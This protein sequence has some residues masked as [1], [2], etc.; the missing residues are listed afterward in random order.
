MRAL[1]PH[2]LEP[3]WRAFTKNAS[4]SSKSL[5]SVQSAGNLRGKRV[6]LR[7]GVN[8]PVKNGKVTNDFRLLSMLPTVKFLRESG[9][10]TIV[11]GHIGR[12]PELSLRPV[13]E[14]L[15]KHVPAMFVSDTVGESAKQA[16][17]KLSDGEILMLE[18]LRSHPGELGNTDAFARALAA[19]GDVYV[20]DAFEVCH[21]EHASIVG[22]PKH[23]P[24]FAG[25]QLL[26]EVEA[27]T[28]ALL[29][30]KPSLFVL[31]G[32]KFETKKPLIE[33]FLSIYDTLFIGGAIAN[34]FFSAMGY[35]VG[36]SATSKDARGLTDIL[37]SPNI[38]LP[39]DVVV[40][41][42]K[43]SR[44]TT[45]DKVSDD[46]YI[47]DIGPE[48]LNLLR[49]RVASAKYILW[50]GPLGDM[51][52]GYVSG[53]E[54]LAEAIASADAESIVGGGDTVASIARLNLSDRLSFLSTGGGSMLQFLADETLPGIRALER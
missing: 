7:A 14:E 54:A 52:I 30:V 38:L 44:I 31:G 22:V 6:F 27:L 33:K 21:R 45:V 19:L 11:T 48:T 46:E 18:N 12:E 36:I 29:P 34:D 3:F 53:T 26:R 9:A 1:I 20:N 5:P 42:G 25:L 15:N 43:K 35:S 47:S 13:C 40:S 16:V 50:N 24:H 17:G 28:N 8:M 2:H 32:A 51:D 37:G 23:L 49:E 4:V 41:K 39:I 10:R